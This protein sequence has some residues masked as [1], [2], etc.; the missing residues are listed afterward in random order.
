MH[1][2]DMECF[3][4]LNLA[5]ES[6]LLSNVMFATKHGTCNIRFAQLNSILVLWMSLDWSSYVDT[7][8]CYEVKLKFFLLL[9]CRGTDISSPHGIPVDLLDRV[10]IIRTLPYTF[11]EIVQVNQLEVE[12]YI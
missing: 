2:L 8:G 11:Q 6:S 9:W 5:L 3:T 1:M 7:C 10:V 12:L 4:Y